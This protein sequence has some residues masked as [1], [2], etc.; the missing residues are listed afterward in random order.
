MGAL[1]DKLAQVMAAAARRD[2][3]AFLDA[4]TDD[5][6][7]RYHVNARPLIGKPWVEKFLDKYWATMTD[8]AW[9]VDRYAENGDVLMVEGYEEYVV[10]ATGR[11]VCHPYMGICEFR[12][13]KIAKMR[14]YFEMGENAAG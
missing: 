8:T 4:L 1:M 10:K 12:D 7:Y 9:R 11:K 5:V 13:G 14:D 6:E 3:A 2:K